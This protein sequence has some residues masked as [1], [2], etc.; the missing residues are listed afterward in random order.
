MIKE[1]FVMMTLAIACTGCSTTTLTT[2]D[3]EG[4]V[5]SVQNFSGDAIG[6]VSLNLKDKMVLISTDGTLIE[7][8]I[9]PPTQDNPTGA[10]KAIYAN[11]KRI[12]CTIPKDMVLN[13]DALEGLAKVVSATSSKDVDITATGIKTGTGK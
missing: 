6:M 10:I 11:G 8:I 3:K 1:I 13:K 7:F 9:E 12:H 5:T 4:K 2:Y